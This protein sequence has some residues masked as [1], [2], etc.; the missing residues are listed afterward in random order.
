MVEAETSEEAEAVTGDLAKVIAAE[1]G[2]A[3]AP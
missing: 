2:T 3:P 1:L